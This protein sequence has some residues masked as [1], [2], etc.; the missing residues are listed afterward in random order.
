MDRELRTKIAELLIKNDMSTRQVFISEVVDLVKSEKAKEREDCVTRLLGLK[1]YL[2]Q[3]T[4]E[5][6][7]VLDQLRDQ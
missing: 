6:E 5:L 1:M 4:E 3:A 7:N 2:R